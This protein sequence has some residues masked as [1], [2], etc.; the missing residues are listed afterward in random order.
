MSRYLTALFV[1]AA[2]PTEL[3]EWHAK[4]GHKVEVKALRIA[5]DKLQFEHSNGSKVVV[6]LD[7]LADE[8]QATLRQHFGIVEPDGDEE[9]TEASPEG[10]P[11][12]DR[13]LELVN[14]KTRHERQIAI[15]NNLA[16]WLKAFPGDL[17]PTN[18]EALNK[19]VRKHFELSH[20]EARH[21]FISYHVALLRSIG[22][23]AL[24]AGNFESIVKRHYLNT[25]TQDEGGAFFRTVPDIAARK[26]VLAAKPKAK[27][28]RHLRVV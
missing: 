26:A 27:P 7:N 19:K 2:D 1:S 8:D 10:E 4:S 25:H 5:E 12:D 22:D 28:A 23:A 16:A 9:T 6:P 17:I 14:I 3:H 13:E 11:A 18:F 20:D 15:S 21:S 24:Q